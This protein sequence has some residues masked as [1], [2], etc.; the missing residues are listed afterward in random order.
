GWQFAYGSMLPILAQPQDPKPI[1]EMAANPNG[2]LDP[3]HV[4]IA[5]Q[6]GGGVRMQVL[7][8]AKGE[9]V[10]TLLEVPGNSTISNIAVSPDRKRIAFTSNA[11]NTISLSE[12]NAFVFE[13]E[14]AK[15]NQITPHWATGDG[16][17]QAIK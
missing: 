12:T 17:A 14:T 6:G 8:P 11:N 9:I 3:G 16:L 4:I 2:E 13:L 1:R 5:R 7:D 10:K 15:V